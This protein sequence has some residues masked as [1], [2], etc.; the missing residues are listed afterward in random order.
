MKDLVSK[1]YKEKLVAF[2]RKRNW[3]NGA[4]PNAA[5]IVYKYMAIT[6]SNSLLD[7]GAG[8][9]AFK[10]AIKKY[11]LSTNYRQHRLDLNVHEYEPGVVGKDEDPPIC[12]V[13]VCF[14]V[15]EHIEPNKIDNVLQ[16]IYDKTRKWAYVSICTVP[17]RKTFPDGQNLHLLV[18][19]S[20]WWLE[21]FKSNWDMLE[22]T[23]T[24]GHVI[25]LLIKK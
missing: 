12:D 7:Y 6:R 21:K 10:Q 14:D 4:P 2:H 18:K 20:S 23:I 25:L 9:G 15:L 11:Q 5:S 8:Y 16:H 17:A 1:K 13:T 24:T 3:G 22:V 19:E